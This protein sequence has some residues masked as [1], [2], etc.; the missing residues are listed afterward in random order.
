[1]IIHDE[2]NNNSS[3]LLLNISTKTLL[4]NDTD[5]SLIQK[6][7]SKRDVDDSDNHSTLEQHESAISNNELSDN[8]DNEEVVP[9]SSSPGWFILNF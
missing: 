5:T 6:E 1:M 2:A 7:N 3:S 9:V 8:Q 4:P